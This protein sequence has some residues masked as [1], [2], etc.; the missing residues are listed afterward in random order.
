MIFL[1]R[2]CIIF[3]VD[4]LCDFVLLRG[5]MILCGDR[6]HNF[7]CGEVA[8]FFLCEG[9]LHGF[10]HSLKLQDLFFWRLRDF[11]W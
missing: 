9:R 2:G 4:R 7:A 6:L 10:S 1:W 11:F 3:L 5:C 8:Q